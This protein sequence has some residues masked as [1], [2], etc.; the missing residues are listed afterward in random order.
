MTQIHD[1]SW[2]LFFCPQERPR[3][4]FTAMAPMTMRN[5]VTGAEE[6]YF[7]ENKRLNRTLTGCMAIIIMVRFLWGDNQECGW[8]WTLIPQCFSEK[9]K[10]KLLGKSY[11]TL[12]IFS[13]WDV[14]NV[15]IIN[16]TRKI[17]GQ[18]AALNNTSCVQISVV[19]MFLIAIILYR[20]ILQIVIYK[21][22]N[23][24]VSSSVSNSTRFHEMKRFKG[25]SLKNALHFSLCFNISLL[26]G[27]FSVF[28]MCVY[29]GCED[30]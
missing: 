3:P 10:E 5:P 26:W 19:L 21:S 9:V 11:K 16:P 18:E 29:S 7:P 23:I 13:V 25:I 20:T 4:E 8:S 1:C 6:P 22:N 2:T 14:R 24:F 12:S 28:C 17:D 27:V 30:S 15:V